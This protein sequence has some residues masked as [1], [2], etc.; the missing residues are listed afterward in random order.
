[1][2]NTMIPKPIHKSS[3]VTANGNLC[4]IYYPRFTSQ[5]ICGAVVAAALAACSVKTTVKMGDNVIS[6]STESDLQAAL[7][8]V[9]QPLQTAAAL[10]S[11]VAQVPSYWYNDNAA[12]VCQVGDYCIK[13]D[14]TR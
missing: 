13:I 10:E 2:S 7:T 6:E 11:R 3:H 9:V 4:G 1:M 8:N 5:A 14:S 12:I